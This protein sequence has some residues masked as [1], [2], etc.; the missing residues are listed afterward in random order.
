MRL[1]GPMLRALASTIILCSFLALPV[2]AQFTQQ[3]P[4]LV[5]TDAVGSSALQGYSVALSGDGNTAIV[6]GANDNHGIGAAWIWTRS[7]GVWTQ[8]AK[9]AGTRHVGAAAQGWSVSLSRDG[10]TAIVGG[11][12]DHS[13][14]GAA[15]VFRRSRGVWT[16]QSKL[17]GTGTI[18]SAAQGSAVALSSDGNTAIVGGQADHFVNR[19][20]SGWVGAAWVFTRSLGAWTQRAKLVGTG[21]IG[22][23]EQGHSV[24]LSSDGDIAIIGGPSDDHAT[25]AVW[26]FKRS[27]RVWSQQ[28]KLIGSGAAGKPVLQGFSVSLSRDGDSIIVGGPGDNG[29][30]GAAWIFR[31]SG[32][33][34]T[35][36]KLIGTGAAGPFGAVQGNSVGLSDNGKTAI[37]GGDNDNNL[38]GA[39][40]VFTR[41][42]G[43]WTQRDKLVGTGAIG[44][45]FQGNSVSLS[46]DG[47][48]AIAGGPG[49]NGNIG[50]VWVYNHAVFAGRPVTEHCYDESVSALSQQYGGLNAAAAE[51]EYSS[52]SSLHDAVLAFCE[53][54]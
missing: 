6:G 19:G 40:W 13:N 43:V 12:V 8:Q 41:S 26:V 24:A 23:A 28:S 39:A 54:R 20:V 38:V 27:H 21:A 44:N 37:I 36:A 53:R 29:N 30:V 1:C 33:G 46:G 45:A 15:W 22:L 34:W 3:G 7:R 35:Q 48:T 11:P 5:G 52:M 4:K 32:G 47:E 2:Q 10:G 49:D 9:L 17:V 51:L 50:A 14:A 31:R 18:G 42:D 25:G 16:Q